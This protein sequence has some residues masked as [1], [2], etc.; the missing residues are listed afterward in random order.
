MCIARMLSAFWKSLHI[1]IILL[2][3]C[4]LCA[5]IALTS[6]M[7]SL[8]I[9]HR[10]FHWSLWYCVI[11]MLLLIEI[12]VKKKVHHLHLNCIFASSWMKT[13]RSIIFLMMSERE[14]I[15]LTFVKWTHISLHACLISCVQLL[16][17]LC[18]VILFCNMFKWTCSELMYVFVSRVSMFTFLNA[19]ATWCKVWFWSVSSLHSLLNSLS[20]LSCWCQI[21]AL[22][23]ISDLT[24]A[25]YTCLAFVKIALHVKIS[26]WLSISILVT[27]FIFICQRCMSHC[28]FMF[29]C[30]SK[31]RTSDFDLITEFSICMLVIML[32][33][34]DFL[35]KCVSSYFSDANVASWMQAHF[36]QT[37]SAICKEW[38]RQILTLL[39]INILNIHL[40]SCFRF[41]SLLT[42]A[43]S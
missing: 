37:S 22:N 6:A 41:A 40:I 3:R 33:L 29:S 7:H 19:S 25:E 30:T 16:T 28:S 36:A 18:N 27:W 26:R 23:A 2:L 17:Q 42:D 24:T 8:Y 5:E 32:N 11:V 43:Y 15:Q 13:F 12:I 34:F 4:N 35:V 10:W 39:M 38:Q 1:S 9:S 14:M 21:D 31:T 20:F